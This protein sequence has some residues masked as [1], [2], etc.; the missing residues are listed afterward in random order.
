MSDQNLLIGKGPLMYIV[1]PN[2]DIGT[3]RMQKSF[4]TRKNNKVVQ[5][6]HDGKM[7]Y[8]KANEAEKKAEKDAEVVISKKDR[9][10]ATVAQVVQTE[11]KPQAVVTGVRKPFKDMTVDEKINYLVNR[12][13]YIPKIPCEVK[14]NDETFVGYVESYKNNVLTLVSNS[15]LNGFRAN[16]KD[17]VSI[18]LLGI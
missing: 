5:I 7:T 14:T 16:S 4:I 12:P 18:R 17:I 15:D 9:R 1:Q 10:E 2:L 6:D 8:E 13:V 3:G 11:E